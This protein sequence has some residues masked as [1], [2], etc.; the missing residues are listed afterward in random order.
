[1]EIDSLKAVMARVQAMAKPWEGWV[2]RC[3]NPP[4]HDPQ[5]LLSGR[6]A[7]THGS[8]W[9]RPDV[10]C[11]VHSSE[12]DVL[13]L[14]EWSATAHAFHIARPKLVV[15]IIVPIQLKL[16]FVVD[17]DE[18]CRVIGVIPGMNSLLS[19]DWNDPDEETRGQQ[20][21]RALFESGIEGFWVPSARVKG[22]RNFNWFPERLQE[23]SRVEGAR[24]P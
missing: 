3:V 8:R 14:Q 24:I 2:Y 13:A 5:Q 10:C 1:M 7:F 23:G 19:D 6:G 11:L 12:S 16:Q 21:G 9:I 18:V 15:R 17:L 22:K 20:L 4:Y